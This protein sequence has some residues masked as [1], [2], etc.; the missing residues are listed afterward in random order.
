MLDLIEVLEFIFQFIGLVTVIV[1][2]YSLIM[3]H[4]QANNVPV[5]LTMVLRGETKN[6]MDRLRL[7]SEKRTFTEVLRSALVVYQYVLEAV[8]R[9]AK[10]V[11]TETDGKEIN[12]DFS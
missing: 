7:L 9:D 6:N 4:R 1:V 2:V 12:L 11:V 8:A 3:W 5:E 10:I